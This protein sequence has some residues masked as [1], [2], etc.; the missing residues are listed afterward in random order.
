MFNRLFAAIMAACLILNCIMFV[1]NLLSLNPMLVVNAL[2]IFAC[3]YS[4]MG[5]LD[6]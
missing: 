1:V 3:I 6:L 4:L 2:G 5:L